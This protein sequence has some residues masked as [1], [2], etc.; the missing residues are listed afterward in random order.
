MEQSILNYVGNNF[1]GNIPYP[2]L[3]TL[4]CIKGGDTFS[5]AEEKR[6]KAS[7]L[8]LTLTRVLKTPAE[9]EEVERIRKRKRVNKEQSRETVPIV[10]AEEELENE[11]I[12][13]FKDYTKKLVLSPNAEETIPALVRVKESEKIRAEVQESSNF[14]LLSLLT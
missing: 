9:D 10:E 14:E 6:P 2:A 4:M 8:T 12:G 7:P 11:E 3:I 1:S 13:G 5:E